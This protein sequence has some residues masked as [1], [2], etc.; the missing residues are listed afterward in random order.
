[1]TVPLCDVLVTGGI[2]LQVL[3]GAGEWAIDAVGKTCREWRQLVAENRLRLLAALPRV[4]YLSSAYFNRTPMPW[5]WPASALLT[6]QLK[7]HD[8][9]HSRQRNRHSWSSVS[10][11]SSRVSC[12]KSQL[13]PALQGLIPSPCPEWSCFGAACAIVEGQ[14]YLCG[15]WD[16]DADGSECSEL[17]DPKCEEWIPMPKLPPQ[18]ACR[19]W[20]AGGVRASQLTICAHVPKNN[21]TS[22]IHL[23]SVLPRFSGKQTTSCAWRF[24]CES[25]NW[26]P[27]KPLLYGRAEAAVGVLGSHI[28]VCGGMDQSEVLPTCERYDPAADSWEALPPLLCPRAWA[29]AGVVGGVL[30]VCGGFGKDWNPVGTAECFNPVT[31]AWE[32]VELP[33]FKKADA[34]FTVARP[35]AETD[36]LS[37]PEEVR[38]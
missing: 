6:G 19:V 26:E 8:G 12:I 36:Q 28:Y 25:G 34:G 4:E 3:S 11:E 31:D 15:G 10:S 32:F 16:D 9:A 37:M 5:Q 22:P 1:M 21:R 30:H 20:E 14:L 18:V 33:A 35:S 38:A 7:L 17:W 24:D 2:P 23:S 29:A 13:E 27:A